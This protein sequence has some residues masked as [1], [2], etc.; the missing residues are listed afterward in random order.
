MN[1]Q[2]VMTPLHSASKSGHVP[3]V[4]L[5]LEAFADPSAGDKVCW[6]LKSRSRICRTVWRGPDG[7]CCVGGVVMKSGWEDATSRSVINGSFA[8]RGAAP[9]SRC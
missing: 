9:Q 4:E 8:G 6:K 3:V 1:Y 7:C 5:L 2:F